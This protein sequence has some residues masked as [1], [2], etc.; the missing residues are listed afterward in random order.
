MNA[1]A[2]SE[3]PDIVAECEKLISIISEADGKLQTLDEITPKK[4]ENQ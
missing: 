4:D 3:H 2:V 1:V